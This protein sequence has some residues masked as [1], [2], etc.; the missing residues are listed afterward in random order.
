[1]VPRVMERFVVVLALLF[2]VG[3]LLVDA[4]K[5]RDLRINDASRRNVA[6]PPHNTSVYQQWADAFIKQSMA[7]NHVPGSVLSVVTSDAVVL[8]RGYGYA[9]MAK[10]VPVDPKTT[11][12][13]LHVTFFDCK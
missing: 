5:P 8:S 12:C 4:I 11:L 7:S 13:T 2:V 3:F 1:M 6:P 10:K 9:N